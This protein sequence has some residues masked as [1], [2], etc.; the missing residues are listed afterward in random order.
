MADLAALLASAV[1]SIPR[2]ERSYMNEQLEQRRPPPA[3][4]GIGR[5]PDA[6]IPPGMD[7][8]PVPAP[9]RDTGW[10]FSRPAPRGFRI[11]PQ[12]NWRDIQ[13]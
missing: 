2:R 9:P 7:L 10:E 8:P 11:N 6:W 12:P 13:I 3:W 5:P 1:T 4:L